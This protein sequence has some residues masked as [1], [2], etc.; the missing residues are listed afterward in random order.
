MWLKSES[1]HHE[2]AKVYASSLC[3]SYAVFCPSVGTYPEMGYHLA[4]NISSVHSLVPVILW[5]I[6]YEGKL[7]SHNLVPNK[8]PEP[9]LSGENNDDQYPIKFSSTWQHNFMMC[10]NFSH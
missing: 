4:A 2:A 9:D 5:M 8:F 1:K 3:W 6:Q 7:I 10:H